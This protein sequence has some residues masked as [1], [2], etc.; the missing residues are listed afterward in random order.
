MRRLFLLAAGLVVAVPFGAPAHAA[1]TNWVALGY[2]HHLV[3][4][5]SGFEVVVLCNA[6]ALTSDQAT[7][8]VATNVSCSV[9]G[10]E[11]NQAMPGRE[12]YTTVSATVVA[13]YTICI[14]G[15]A[16]FVDPVANEI[17]IPSAGPDCEI[18]PI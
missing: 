18:W 15:Q 1:G 13:P 9:N 11:A 16:A 12:S 17:A 2:E 14:S 3:A 8:P 10:I 6:S 5:D 7:V 4:L